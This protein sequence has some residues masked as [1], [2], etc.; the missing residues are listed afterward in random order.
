MS[1]SEWNH[2]EQNESKLVYIVNVIF[3]STKFLDLLEIKITLRS[4]NIL[5]RFCIVKDSHVRYTFHPGR[6]NSYL[7]S[8][9]QDVEDF[10]KKI[11]SSLF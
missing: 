1:W 2:C 7:T 3:P 9:A 10:L 6:E 4:K 8:H 11:K 5:N